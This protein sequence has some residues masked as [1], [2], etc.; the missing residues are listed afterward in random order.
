MIKYIC[1]YLKLSDLFIVN[2]TRFRIDCLNV[3]KVL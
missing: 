1:Y 3:V 2:L